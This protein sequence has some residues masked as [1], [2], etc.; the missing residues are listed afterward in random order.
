M[1]VYSGTPLVS[2]EER[3]VYD[4]FLMDLRTGEAKRLTTDTLTEQ[5]PVFV[6][7]GK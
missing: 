7:A 4:I 2:A 5:A 1:L 3:P 6:R